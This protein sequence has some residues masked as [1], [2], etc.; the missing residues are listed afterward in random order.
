M[1]QLDAAG[2]A[3]VSDSVTF[4]TNIRSSCTTIA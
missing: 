4:L 1:K 2:V 3:V